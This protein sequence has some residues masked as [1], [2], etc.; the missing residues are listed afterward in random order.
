MNPTPRPFHRF[1]L[2]ATLVATLCPAFVPAFVPAAAAVDVVTRITDLNPGGAHSLAVFSGAVFDGK[3]YFQAKDG[4]GVPTDLWVYDGVNAPSIVP[5]GADISPESFA[6]W[7]GALWFG[8]GPGDDRELWRYD[9]VTPP[10]EALDV[11]PGGDGNVRFLFP[12]GD[13][14]CFNAETAG[15]GAELACWDGSSSPSIFNLRAGSSGSSPEWYGISQGKLYFGAFVDGVGDEPHVYDG[16]VAPV[17][18][19]DVRPGSSSSNPEYFTA[20]GSDLYFR[21]SDEDGQ[22]RVWRYDGVEP[23]EMISADFDVE[24]G[25][26]A[27]LGSLYSTGFLEDGMQELHRWNGSEFLRIPFVPAASALGADSFTSFAGSLFLVAG[28]S[29]G[30]D[31]YRYCGN[32]EAQRVTDA[33]A[34]GSDYVQSELIVLGDR[35]LFVAR[36]STHGAELWALDADEATFCHGFEDGVTAGW[37]TTVP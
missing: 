7:Q 8:A 27:W 11:W 34:T 19:D 36:T 31:L 3:L 28:S 9:G 37:S 13:L 6:L 26:T 29:P 2:A 22:G 25:T 33:F 30:R 14:L 15:N 12:F 35:L 16:L 18:V 23:P 20:F 17:L 1:V 24:G 10:A 21:A 5:G 32:G 4:P